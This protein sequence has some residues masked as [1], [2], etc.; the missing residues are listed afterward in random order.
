MRSVILLLLC[1]VGVAC[2]STSPTADL[3]GTWSGQV[4]LPTSGSA[5][6]VTWLAT[7]AGTALTG[8]ATLVKP[9]VNVP[10]TGTLSGTLNGSQLALAYL[11]PGGS[12]PGFPACEVSGTGTATFQGDTITGTLALNFTACAGSGLE[13]TG[14]DLLALT[15]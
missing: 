11:A 15:K 6:R 12:V 3:T 4:G 8:P 7:Q 1:F 13:P 14:S 5:L 9:A 10:A 2:D